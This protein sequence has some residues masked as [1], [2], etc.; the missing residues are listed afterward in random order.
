MVEKS[1]AA[2][3]SLQ[4]ANFTLDPELNDMVLV[5]ESCAVEQTPEKTVSTRDLSLSLLVTLWDSC[6]LQLSAFKRIFFIIYLN[7]NQVSEQFN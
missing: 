6:L 7:W 4:L 5:V 2:G 1:A 3:K